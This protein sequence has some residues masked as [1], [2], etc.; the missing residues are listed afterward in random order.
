MSGN[1]ID[2]YFGIGIGVST[3]TILVLALESDYEVLH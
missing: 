2:I 3:D 1:A